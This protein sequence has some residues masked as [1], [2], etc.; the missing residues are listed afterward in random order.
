MNEIDNR[1]VQKVS[2]L[3][4]WASFLGISVL[5]DN[6]AECLI[7]AEER[8][9]RLRCSVGLDPELRFYSALEEVIGK[10]DTNW[11]AK[12]FT[13]CALPSYSYHVTVWDGVNDENVSSIFDSHRPKIQEFHEK[14]PDSLNRMPRELEFIA[15]AS[16]LSDNYDPVNFRF[17]KIT[18]WSNKV[19]VAQLEPSD[20]NSESTLDSI[21]AARQDLY[22]QLSDELGVE[23]LREYS[24]H[25]SLGYFAN[26]NGGEKASS[27][28]DVWTQEFER[29]IGDHTITFDSMSIYGFTDMVSFYKTLTDHTR[30]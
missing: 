24:P 28:I 26:S 10:L 5:F 4:E 7:A 22:R 6:P 1:K 19:L 18:K 11:L 23:G 16:L 25:V 21:R 17:K 30:I 3:P 20:A 8:T 13:F 12:E 29:H 27:S 9:V 2:P 14:L 15:R